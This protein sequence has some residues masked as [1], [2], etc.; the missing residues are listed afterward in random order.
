MFKHSD[1]H[2]L[3][4]VRLLLHLGSPG[5]W[6]RQWILF[7]AREEKRKP[8]F[9]HRT[10]LPRV[11]FNFLPF[12]FSCRAHCQTCIGMRFYSLFL[13]YKVLKSIA[14]VIAPRPIS[15][16][17][18]SAQTPP[19]VATW[20]PF[21][22]PPCALITPHRA[23]T[24]TFPST[25]KVCSFIFSNSGI[26]PQCSAPRPRTLL[27]LYNTLHVNFHMVFCAVRGR[28]PHSSWECEFLGQTAWMWLL[29]LPP[30]NLG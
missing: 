23:H 20:P 25:Q 12:I 16:F 6:Q 17:T 14:D 5:G 3:V 15:P 13:N 10:C 2:R 22:R 8:V 30:E 19:A 11:T 9:L 7:R 29:D 26:Y 28:V 21:P 18:P 24:N 27:C 4:W 1:T